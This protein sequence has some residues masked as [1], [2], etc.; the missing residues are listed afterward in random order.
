MFTDIKKKNNERM[1]IILV[2]RTHK[3][4]S[5][6]YFPQMNKPQATHE[7]ADG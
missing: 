2:A 3:D 4:T 7:N 5:I 6:P 1:C